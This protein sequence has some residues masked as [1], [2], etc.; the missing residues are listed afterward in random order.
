MKDQLALIF[1]F[2]FGIFAILAYFF[3][4]LDELNKDY[5]INWTL[6]IFGFSMALGIISLVKSHVTKILRRSPGYFYNV[7]ALLGFSVMVFLK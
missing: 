6:I 5:V 1:C 4:V 2:C 3:P 7:V